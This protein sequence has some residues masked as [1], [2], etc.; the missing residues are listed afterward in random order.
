[1]V[2]F[3]IFCIL[4]LKGVQKMPE[5]SALAKRVKAYRASQNKTQFE[6]AEEIG[7]SMDELSLIERERAN[8]SLGTM[9]KI[10]AHMG[11]T[12]SE[13]LKTEG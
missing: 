4:Q 6:I 13:L 2:K 8:P 10:A 5:V 1:M 9:Q 12:V 7:I 3:D 11:I